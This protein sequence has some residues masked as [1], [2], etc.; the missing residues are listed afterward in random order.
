MPL[1][2]YQCGKCSYIFELLRRMQDADSDLEC[3]RC[4]STRVERQFSTFSA[5]ACG[6]SG[7][8]T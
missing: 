2:E 5:G 3:P 1:Y 6:G 8:F 4:H 7:K